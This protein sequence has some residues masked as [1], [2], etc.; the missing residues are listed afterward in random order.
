MQIVL[1][2]ISQLIEKGEKVLVFSQYLDN[3]HCVELHL[4]QLLGLEDG[5]DFVHIDGTMQVPRRD[6]L[7]DRF[8][9]DSR[10]KVF[11][12]SVKACGLGVNLQVSSHVILL[13]INDNPMFDAQAIGRS[14]RLGQKKDVF[15]YIVL[16]DQSTEWCVLRR[17]AMKRVTTDAVV[18][19]NL[20]RRA[21]FDLK[22]EK[23]DPLPAEV[24][25]A[26]GAKPGSG[27]EVPWKERITRDEICGRLL[28]H[29]LNH[30]IRRVD[31]YESLLADEEVELA[32]EEHREHITELVCE[33]LDMDEFVPRPAKRPK[34][35]P[36]PL[37]SGMAPMVVFPSVDPHTGTVRSTQSAVS[38]MSRLPTPSHATR[39]A[40]PILT[41][42]TPGTTPS[43]LRSDPP[44]S[45]SSSGGFVMALKLLMKSAGL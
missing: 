27:E 40:V 32:S 23:V 33:R 15:I 18:D 44:P 8:R 5:V 13:D 11:F 3:L 7:V 20:G 41:T 10:L 37:P 42:S 39:P 14:Y 16:V 22:T 36:V 21:D 6:A 29:D 26:P 35:I 34:N 9:Q 38:P 31:G 2:L 24:V 30:L 1:R 43:A 45:S 19:K 4:Q 25:I 28:I 17:Q 12:G